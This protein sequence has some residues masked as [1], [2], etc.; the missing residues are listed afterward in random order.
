MDGVR[1][2]KALLESGAVDVNDE[3]YFNLG[4]LKKHGFV[5]ERLYDDAAEN[6]SGDTAA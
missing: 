6:R 5:G 4:Y 2:V 1:Q 3:R